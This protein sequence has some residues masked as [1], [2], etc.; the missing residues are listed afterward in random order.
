MIFLDN[1]IFGID[2]FPVIHLVIHALDQPQMTASLV[3][4]VVTVTSD[5][6]L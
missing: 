6:I 1:V 5:K 2:L 3:I 4:K